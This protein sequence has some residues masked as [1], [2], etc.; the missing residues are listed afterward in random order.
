[1]N[2]LLNYPEIKVID[3]EVKDNNVLEIDVKKL[4]KWLGVPVVPTTA[5]TGEGFKE[6]VDRI[7]EAKAPKV[8]K[9]TRED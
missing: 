1:M 7:S 8:R 4:E 9:H 5:V 2:I 6:L 3:K